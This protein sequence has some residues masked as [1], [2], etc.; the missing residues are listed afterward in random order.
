VHAMKEHPFWKLMPANIK[1]ALDDWTAD[2]PAAEIEPFL[3][4]I[5]RFLFLESDADSPLE[6]TKLEQ[7]GQAEIHAGVAIQSGPTDGAPESLMVEV[8]VI[9]VAAILTRCLELLR[10]DRNSR[11][12]MAIFLQV[13]AGRER[14]VGAVQ[15]YLSREAPT[16]ESPCPVAPVALLRWVSSQIDM[17]TLFLMQQRTHGENAELPSDLLPAV[18]DACALAGFSA[19]TCTFSGI[20]DTGPDV[21]AKLLDKT[22][23]LESLLLRDPEQ[24]ATCHPTPGNALRSAYVR[25]ASDVELGIPDGFDAD[26]F[27]TVSK[28]SIGLTDDELRHRLDGMPSDVA[29]G[30]IMGGV[31]SEGTS[32][33]RSKLIRKVAH[34]PALLE[35]EPRCELHL[36]SLESY[37]RA[38]NLLEAGDGD[39]CDVAVSAGRAVDSAQRWRWFSA[40]L[41][42]GT[43]GQGIAPPN[44]WMRATVSVCMLLRQKPSIAALEE[45]SYWAAATA[46]LLRRAPDAFDGP[47][48]Q[49]YGL[50]HESFAH[51]VLGAATHVLDSGLDTQQWPTVQ[52]DIEHLRER[53]P[54]SGDAGSRPEPT[55]AT[56]PPSQSGSIE[57]PNGGSAPGTVAGILGILG[58]CVFGSLMFPLQGWA[59]YR[60]WTAKPRNTTAVALGGGGLALSVGIVV[61][62]VLA[63]IAKA[64]S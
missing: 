9:R 13:C 36:R 4:A 59:L 43:R 63:Q 28:E 21:A 19:A 12:A 49:E 26:A 1:A 14:A 23:Q 25:H 31:L 35:V 45:W 15:A 8:H 48:L 7:A 18:T 39:A 57:S 64:L 30:V 27:I 2:A 40:G 24:A 58:M 47:L 41:E 16:K 17:T 53:Y 10:A 5:A 29:L 33:E 44:S 55:D 42:A 11:E 54:Q 37:C 38:M 60:G 52:D 51:L 50:S 20:A 6:L 56:A 32:D 3:Q 61:L 22:E 34:R 62:V 46:Y